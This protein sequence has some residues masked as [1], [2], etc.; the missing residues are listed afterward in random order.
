MSLAVGDLVA[1]DEIAFISAS[2]DFKGNQCEAGV[3][4]SIVDARSEMNLDTDDILC[5]VM[6][7]DGGIHFFYEE[8]LHLLTKLSP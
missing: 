1:A 3:V 8:D 4:I 5:E 6:L 7:N 2:L